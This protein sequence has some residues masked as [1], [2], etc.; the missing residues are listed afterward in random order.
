MCCF[1]GFRRIR[2]TSKTPRSKTTFLRQ[3]RSM[4]FISYEYHHS[5]TLPTSAKRLTTILEQQEQQAI[6]PTP[7]SKASIIRF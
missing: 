4:S 6:A 2:N 5:T 1:K 3:T 7:E